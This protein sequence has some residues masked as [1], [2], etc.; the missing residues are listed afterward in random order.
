MT[1]HK[2]HSKSHGIY[3][4]FLGGWGTKMFHCGKCSVYI[5]K[6]VACTCECYHQMKVCIQEPLVRGKWP[7]VFWIVISLFYCG[8]KSE[9]T[10]QHKLLTQYLN[11]P[12]NSL[13]L[14]MVHCYQWGL[15]LLSGVH[16]YTCHS[17]HCWI[18]ECFYP[19]SAIWY[20]RAW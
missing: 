5:W 19:S 18:F 3:F 15:H 7:H 20:S 13:S 17:W 16:F 6:H 10:V 2:G 11:K 9:E 8:V 14:P 1:K 12:Q 4:L